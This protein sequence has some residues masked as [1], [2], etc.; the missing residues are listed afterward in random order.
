VLESEAP[1]AYPAWS[2]GWRLS[3]TEGER[4]VL[5]KFKDARNRALKRET[6]TV[7][8]DRAAQ[9]A[10]GLP[11]ELQFFFEE[12]GDEGPLPTG[13]GRVL[14]G[15]LTP[16]HAEEEILPACRQYTDLLSKLVAAFL[17]AHK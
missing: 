7:S 5:G 16:E 2:A 8:E 1:T 9:A 13:L 14:K 4:Q 6:P 17:V 15:R 11:P 3:L 10:K 12:L